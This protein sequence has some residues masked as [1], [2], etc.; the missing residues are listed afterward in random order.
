MNKKALVFA[1]SLASLGMSGCTTM[2]SV[3]ESEYSCPGLPNGVAC[4]SVIDNYEMTHGDLDDVR[5]RIASNDAADS[6]NEFEHESYSSPSKSELSTVSSPQIKVEHTVASVPNSGPVGL[7]IVNNPYVAKGAP[8]VEKPVAHGVWF[9]PRVGSD[10][11]YYGERDV[12]FFNGAARWKDSQ[13][14]VPVMTGTKLNK[15]KVF[16]PLQVVKTKKK[17]KKGEA[18]VTPNMQM[19]AGVNIFNQ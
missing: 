8:K 12:Y 16:T 19:P 7:E 10:G 18:S 13:N 9:A 5:Q 1:M 11:R 6:E 3:G 4:Q 14:F 2:M 17:A 15:P